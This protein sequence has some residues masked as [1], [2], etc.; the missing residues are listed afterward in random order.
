MQGIDHC[1]SPNN[2]PNN[3]DNTEYND[4]N[5]FIYSVLVVK[6]HTNTGKAALCLYEDT[7]NG[8]K[9][10]VTMQQVDEDGLGAE[11]LEEKNQGYEARP[12]SPKGLSSIPQSMEPYD[13]RIGQDQ[14]NTC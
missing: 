13:S 10:F 1:R 14:R 4:A 3:D 6:V 11:D 2:V 8:Q 12:L 7:Q 5:C 9:T